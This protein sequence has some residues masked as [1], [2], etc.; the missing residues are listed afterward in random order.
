MTVSLNYSHLRT[1]L[2]EFRDENNIPVTLLLLSLLLMPV[3]RLIIHPNSGL[4]TDSRF[5]HNY[6]LYIE[7]VIIILTMAI[8]FKQQSTIFRQSRVLWTFFFIWLVAAAVGLEQSINVGKAVIKNAE[9]LIHFFFAL[10]LIDI[11]RKTSPTDRSYISATAIIGILLF[12]PFFFVATFLISAN[13]EAFNW[14]TD[15]PAFS[16]VR[17]L[18]FTMAIVIMLLAFAR[19]C[20]EIKDGRY[21]YIFPV[22]LSA[23]WTILFW[24]GGR[25]SILATFSTLAI[26]TAIFTWRS[27]KSWIRLNLFAIFTGAFL[28]ILLP[29]P[30]DSYG[31]F[32]LYDDTIDSQSINQLSAS[33]LTIWKETTE[34]IIEAPWTGFGPN[35]TVYLVEFGDGFVIHP[36]NIVLQALLAW[37]VIGG[38]V[39]LGFIVTPL[40]SSALSLRKV[41]DM[42]PVSLAGFALA[43][44]LFVHA[45]V[46]STLYHPF[47]IFYFV[48]GLSL[49]MTHRQA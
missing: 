46:D 26:C 20:M 43:L 13:S 10:S 47:T 40:L 23:C 27:K 33:R 15:L 41:K 29:A 1:R 25:G 11:F 28:S 37:G 24:S 4:L 9:F 34:H 31:I 39:F 2:T 48:V 5:Y 38:I 44:M 6:P 36:H 16:N 35:Q 12:L 42:P 22:L 18:S 32:R 45:F 17:H 49:A 19:P 3:F 7:L 14:S 21:L 8:G 30:N